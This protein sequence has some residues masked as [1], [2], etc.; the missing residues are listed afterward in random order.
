[1]SC[2]FL[3]NDCQVA[4]DEVLE[5][6]GTGFAWTW[7]MIDKDVTNDGLILGHAMN[8]EL[9]E[10]SESGTSRFFTRTLHPK[11]TTCLTFWY[12]LQTKDSSGLKVMAIEGEFREDDDELEEVML[13]IKGDQ[14]SDWFPIRKEIR[15][16]GPWKLAFVSNYPKAQERSSL[17]AV[18]E[19]SVVRGHC[20]PI[21]S[22][23][24]EDD[25]CLW[26]NIENF[27]SVTSANRWTRLPSTINLSWQID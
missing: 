11:E 7:R 20:Q 23:D 3:E 25:S 14:G 2:S 17:V 27:G 10:S 21:T 5:K 8:L 4:V 16:R 19:I 6:D 9:S 26:R 1:M 12:K 13:D 15:L 18:D 24:F 22:C